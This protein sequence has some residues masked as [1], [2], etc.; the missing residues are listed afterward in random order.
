MRKTSKVALNNN[1][2]RPKMVILAWFFGFY[3]QTIKPYAN[4]HIHTE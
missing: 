1:K 4:K 3:Q 2:N